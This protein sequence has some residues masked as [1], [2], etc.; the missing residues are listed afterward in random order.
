MNK[1]IES[2]LDRDAIC[3]NCGIE[4]PQGTLVIIRRDDSVGG[5]CSRE[6]LASF[7][8]NPFAEVEP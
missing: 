1:P 8:A 3:T 6:C 5:F 2:T 7:D 4:L